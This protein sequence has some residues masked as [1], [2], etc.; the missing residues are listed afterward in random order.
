M[1]ARIAV[2]AIDGLGRQGRGELEEMFRQDHEQ[3]RQRGAA[4]WS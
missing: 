4:G 2:A 3:R 1:P